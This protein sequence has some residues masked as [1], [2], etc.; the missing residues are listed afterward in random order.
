MKGRYHQWEGK[1][2]GAVSLETF[3]LFLFIFARGLMARTQGGR[4][5]FVQGM[6]AQRPFDALLPTVFLIMAM[7]GSL[8]LI[9]RAARSGTNCAYQ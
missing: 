6:T 3:G 1:K 9:Q 7:A 2:R 5:R 4:R 8:V